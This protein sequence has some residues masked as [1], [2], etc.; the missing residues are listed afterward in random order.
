MSYPSYQKKSFYNQPKQPLTKRNDVLDRSS[1][2]QN[3]ENQFNIQR[4]YNVCNTEQSDYGYG[5]PEK[6]FNNRYQ[7]HQREEEPKFQ[8][9]NDRNVDRYKSYI[10]S[11]QRLT[12]I[13]SQNYLNYIM[14]QKKNAHS[15]YLSQSHQ[16][17]TL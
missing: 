2:H 14:N 8:N 11:T 6:D 4:P 12:E 17:T 10:S 7:S 5:T 1:F 13:N 3:I 9:E 15:R 16:L